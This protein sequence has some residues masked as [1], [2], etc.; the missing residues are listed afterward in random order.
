MGATDRIFHPQFST[1]PYWWDETPPDDARHPLPDRVDVL[2]A[3]SGYCGLAAALEIARAG[4]SVLV[5]DA[6]RIGEGASTRNA[7]MVSGG[8]KIPPRLRRTL[9]AERYGRLVRESV[10]SFYFLESLI[11]REGLAVRYARC[12]RFTAAHTPGAHVRQGEQAQTLADETGFKL[13]LVPRS[14]QHEE[15]GS[16]Y[17]HGGLVLDEAGSLDPGC[18]HRALVQACVSAGVQVCGHAELRD[19]VRE[20]GR[21]KARTARGSTLADTVL[22][23]TNGY[24]GPLLPYLQRRL[25]PVASFVIATEPIV[26]ELA[27]RL[28]PKN[29]M[30]VDTKKILCYYRLSP[31]GRRV[32]FGGRASFHDADI[33]SSAR[34]LHRFMCQVWPQLARVRITHA[35]KGNVAFTFDLLPHLGVHQG[36]HYAGGCLGSGVTAATWLGHRSAQRILGRAGE[37]SAFEDLRFPASPLYSGTPWFLPLIGGYYRMQDRIDRLTGR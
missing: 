24:S 23:A 2:I 11:R 29:R 31:D 5:V 13:H 37:R 9:G 15:I 1:R 36:I 33:S 20:G 30:L 4:V 17:Y 6:G 28:S 21:F 35:W 34:T 3:G 8:L 7:G 26:P 22:L 12:G 10:D 18:F 25:I 32:I 19:I 27:Q 16:D 14:S